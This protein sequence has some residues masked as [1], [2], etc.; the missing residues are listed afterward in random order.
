[1]C[2]K[3]KEAQLTLNFLYFLFIVQ[4]KRLSLHGHFC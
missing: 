3:N 2:I 1:M 4:M